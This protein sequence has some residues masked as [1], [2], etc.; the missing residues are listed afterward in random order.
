MTN[1]Q[2]N[3]PA[4][5]TSHPSGVE[6]IAITEHFGF[7]VGNAI[8]YLWRAGLKREPG[9]SVREKKLEDLKKARWYIDREI[10]RLSREEK[11]DGDDAGL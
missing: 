8:K 11:R 2:V 1:D 10:G 4:H 3:H 9:R 7:C 6:C 5:Y